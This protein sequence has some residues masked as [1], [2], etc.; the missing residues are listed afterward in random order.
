MV[1]YQ[2]DVNGRLYCIYQGRPSTI[3]LL[4]IAIPFPTLETVGSQ[5]EALAAWVNLATVL[6]DILTKFNQCPQ[7][8]GD[9]DGLS[10][11]RNS[12]FQWL[13]LLPENLQWN[14]QSTTLPPPGICALHMQFLSATILLYRPLAVYVPLSDNKGHQP[15]DTENPSFLA[16]QLCTQNAIRT[17]KILLEFKRKHG[18]HKIFSTVCHM[19]LTAA[20]SL[21]SEISTETGAIRKVEERKW[22]EVCFDILNELGGTFPVMGR[23]LKILTHIVEWCG[24][25]E[26]SHREKSHL[27]GKSSDMSLPARECPQPLGQGDLG[28]NGIQPL[29]KLIR[30]TDGL[31]ESGSDMILDTNGFI[32]PFPASFTLGHDLMNG[33]RGL[34]AAYDDLFMD[35]SDPVL[36]QHI[37]DIDSFEFPSL[38]SRQ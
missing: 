4:D 23:N 37:N 10:E 24:Y 36:F 5:W 19:A 1:Y 3:K 28:N 7:N 33:F 22:L 25:R 18:I 16:Q 20:L 17:S 32:N 15:G 34:D 9:L 29:G 38:V 30:D 13:K 31:F 26:L 11:T 12:L 6:D 35:F 21:I 2:A 14:T 8:K 27:G